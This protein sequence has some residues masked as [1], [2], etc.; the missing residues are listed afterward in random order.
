MRG[1]LVPGGDDLDRHGQDIALAANGLD[2]GGY[3]RIVAQPLAHPADEQV[4][5]AIEQLGLAPCVK[6]RSW[7]RE[8]TRWG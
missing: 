4:D 8:S 2:V 5:R 6:L 7:S 3:A 1:R